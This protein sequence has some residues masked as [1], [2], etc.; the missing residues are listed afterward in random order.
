MKNHFYIGYAGNKR[1]EVEIIYN[2]LNLSN[3]TTIIEPYCGTCA[4]SYYIWLKHPNLKFILN[5]NNI[6]LKEI[7]E[8]IK[9][10]VKCIEFEKIINEQYNIYSFLFNTIAGRAII[11]LVNFI[12]KN[13][14]STIPD[15]NPNNASSIILE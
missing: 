12:G 8:I 13:N 14:P 7:Y 2:S 6:Y 4:I 5:D 3:I 1:Q 11:V 15:A 10:D 9:D